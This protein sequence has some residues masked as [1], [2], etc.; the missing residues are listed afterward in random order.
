MVAT[1]LAIPDTP[2]ILNYINGTT[3]ESEISPN[4]KLLHFCS[5]PILLAVYII[6]MNDLKTLFL[7]LALCSKLDMNE[8]KGEITELSQNVQCKLNFGKNCFVLF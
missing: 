3:D 4:S 5:I 7:S 6:K 1:P 2:W 8:S